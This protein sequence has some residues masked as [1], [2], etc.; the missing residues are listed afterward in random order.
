MSRKGWK[1]HSFKLGQCLLL[2]SFYFVYIYMHSKIQHGVW[3]LQPSKGYLSFDSSFL[4]F[5]FNL[6]DMQVNWWF[7]CCREGEDTNFIC[8]IFPSLGFI[9]SDVMFTEWGNS[10]L[11]LFFKEA[12]KRKTRGRETENRRSIYTHCVIYWSWEQIY[13]PV[14]NH[15]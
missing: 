1:Q 7:D 8:H 15:C 3:C 11:S 4:N 2:C 13:C 10:E 14:E 6:L 5:E 9:W 12:Q